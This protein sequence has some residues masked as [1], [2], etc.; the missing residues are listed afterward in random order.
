MLDGHGIVSRA[1]FRAWLTKHHASEK[2][3]I[4]RCY[5]V[6]HADRGVTYVEA[7]DEAL[8]FGWIDGVRRPLDAQSF[9]HRF[10]PRQLKSAWSD[11]NIRKFTAL[12]KQGL[13]RPAGQAACD[14]RKKSADNDESRE[15]QLDPAFT[16]RLRADAGAWRYWRTLPPGYKRLV[17]FWVMSAR[18]PETRERRF[19]LLFRYV[20]LGQRIPLNAKDRT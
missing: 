1:A 8:C 19:A 10:T 17:S 2:E 5:K 6:A 20:R 11:V 7:L 16:K 12:K 14:R 4:V 18:Q 15:R 3:L 9:T 13:I